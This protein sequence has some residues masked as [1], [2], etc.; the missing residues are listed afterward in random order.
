VKI[1]ALQAKVDAQAGLSAAQV[2]AHARLS[3]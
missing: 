3:A 1:A 2:D